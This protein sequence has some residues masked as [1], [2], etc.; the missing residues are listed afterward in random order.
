M[1]HF[2]YTTETCTD[3]NATIKSKHGDRM[4]HCDQCGKTLCAT[5]N[6]LHEGDTSTEKGSVIDRCNTCGHNV[7]DQCSHKDDIFEHERVCDQCAAH[8]I[9]CGRETSWRHLTN[10]C[11]CY[12]CDLVNAELH[13][14]GDEYADACTEL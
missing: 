13:T 5:C 1:A 4:L 10:D 8:C 6:T 3:C 14:Y 9:Q 2:H 7:C 12:D 11:V